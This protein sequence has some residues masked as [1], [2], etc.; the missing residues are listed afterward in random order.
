MLT[1]SIIDRDSIIANLKLTSPTERKNILVHVVNCYKCMEPGLAMGTTVVAYPDCNFMNALEKPEERRTQWL[2]ANIILDFV[3]TL[4]RHQIR[5]GLC[6]SVLY[7][8][9]GKDRIDPSFAVMA[10]QACNTLLRPTKMQ[11][12][13]PH[14]ENITADTYLIRSFSM[15]QHDEPLVLSVLESIERIDCGAIW[16]SARPHTPL[17]GYAEAVVQEA[18]K[19]VELQYFDAG[20]VVAI[21]GRKLYARLLSVCPEWSVITS[22]VHDD[23]YPKIKKMVDI[24]HKSRMS[25]M[26]DLDFLSL[27]HAGHHFHKCD[28]LGWSV[29]SFD[30]GLAQAMAA[31]GNVTVTRTFQGGMAAE[32]VRKVS[33]TVQADLHRLDTYNNLR[34]GTIGLFFYYLDNQLE[35]I[36]RSK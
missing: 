3:R 25:G 12:T 10:A 4:H 9:L 31:S 2:A 7:E 14:P 30:A 26:A 5:L 34:S 15:I 8:F 23:P 11:V 33:S 6:P 32:E 36:L 16:E 35:D 24:D 19:D 29:L 28:T 17:P 27:C 13:I 18:I 1:S 20:C 21:L 22:S